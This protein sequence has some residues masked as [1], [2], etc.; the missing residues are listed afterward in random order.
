MVMPAR[1]LNRAAELMY[2]RL[3]EL[4]QQLKAEEERLAQKDGRAQLIK[5]EVDEHD[6]AEVISRWTGIPVSKLLEGEVQK[7]LHLGEDPLPYRQPPLSPQ[8]PSAECSS[9]CY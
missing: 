2:G 9:G 6:I 7:L 1:Q 3:P 4:E 5:E 8:W